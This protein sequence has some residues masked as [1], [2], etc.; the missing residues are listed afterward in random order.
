MSR[1]V[2]LPL[3]NSVWSLQQPSLTLTEEREFCLWLRTAAITHRFRRFS[4]PRCYSETETTTSVVVCG[5]LIKAEE[6]SG[7]LLLLMCPDG[8]TSG[9]GCADGRRWH[10]S[11]DDWCIFKRASLHQATV[12]EPI[13]ALYTIEKSE[14]IY[15]CN[16]QVADRT[17]VAHLWRTAINIRPENSTK[18]TI[19][20]HLLGVCNKITK[21]RAYVSHTRILFSEEI[22]HVC[23]LT[24]LEYV[25]YDDTSKLHTMHQWLKAVTIQLM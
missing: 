19:F 21:V 3:I 10:A 12:T 17:T 13:T 6:L 15:K 7:E 4:L 23:I 24:S 9:L 25:A 8:L 11:T 5:G 20:Y 22:A 18:V 16:S 14:A 2:I 1:L